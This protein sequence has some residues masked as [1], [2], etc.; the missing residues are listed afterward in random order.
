LGIDA[1]TPTVDVII[2]VYNEGKNILKVLSAFQREVKT[3]V[4][5]LICYDHEDDST[6]SALK[7]SNTLTEYIVLVKNRFHGAFGAVRT[8]FLAG[9]SDAVITYMADDDYNTGLIDLLIAGYRAG[10]DIVAPSRFIPGGIFQGCR[11]PKNFLVR[12]TSWSMHALA[13]VPIHDATNGFRLFS[14]QLLDA[15][16]LESTEGFTYSIELLVKCHRLGFPMK[17]IPASW[18]ERTYG[19]SRFKVFR[20]A[21][22]YLRWYWY[23]FAT[24]YLW[25]KT[26]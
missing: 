2:P 22:A 20:W 17:E 9:T 11:W 26:V 23:A 1:D 13:R 15:V 25:R 19:Q 18:Y 8:G 7:S 6:L 21:S 5:I 4:R 3:P 24:T 12:A 14:R 16:Q 10:Y